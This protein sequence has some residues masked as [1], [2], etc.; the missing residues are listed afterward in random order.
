MNRK[1]LSSSMII[2]LFLCTSCV[3]NS[4]TPVSNLQPSE[5]REP[6]IGETYEELFVQEEKINNCDGMNPT[7]IFRRSLEQGQTTVFEVVVEAGGLMRGTPIP[8]VLQFELEAKLKAALQRANILSDVK[9]VEIPLTTPNGESWK[10]KITWRE[11][12]VKGIIEV[13]YQDKAATISFQRL[14]SF[15]L[16]DRS[17]ERLVCNG[18][19]HTEV[20]PEPVQPQE[21]ITPLPSNPLSLTE[22]DLNRLLG[23]NNWRCVDGY[24]TAVSIDKLPANF[25]VQFPFNRI[26]A[27][28]NFYYEGETVPDAGYYATGWLVGNLPNNSCSLEQV[29]ITS[30]IINGLFDAGNWQCLKQ[31]PTGVLVRN[32]PSGYVVQTPVIYIDKDDARYYQGENVPASGPATIWFPGNIPSDQCP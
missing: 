18:S 21:K 22:D 26:D 24:P 31:F 32:M 10:H 29:Q 2:V 13:I 5:I 15:Q 6:E 1:L 11:K 12:K 25:V 19:A 20:T 30:E 3:G 9:T 27:R 28:S 16:E 17:S 4:P 23:E 8:E 14:V 7:T